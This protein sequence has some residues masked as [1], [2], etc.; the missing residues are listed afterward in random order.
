MDSLESK[1]NAL[2]NAWVEF[3]TGI[4]DSRLIKTAVDF[5][6]NILET[7]N[8]ITDALGSVGT[9]LSRILLLFGGLRAAG[10][11]L[12]SIASTFGFENVAK[13]VGKLN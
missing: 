6:T 13:E 10:G 9:P 2:S 11:T 3:T 4:A 7:I 1:L 8:E 12:G 5:L